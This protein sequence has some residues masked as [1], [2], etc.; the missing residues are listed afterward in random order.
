[1]VYSYIYKNAS[2][3]LWASVKLELRGIVY[4][5]VTLKEQ[6]SH[7]F[8]LNIS[9]FAMGSTFLR[10]FVAPWVCVGVINVV[11]LV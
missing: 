10:T 3:P 11:R 2:L 4:L 5:M 7:V 1:M 8:I 9:Y 6:M